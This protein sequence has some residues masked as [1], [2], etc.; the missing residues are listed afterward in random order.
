MIVPTYKEKC[1][2]QDCVDCRG[3]QLIH[4]LKIWERII[5]RMLRDKQFVFMSGRRTA[6]AIFAV[7]QR[8]EK[9]RG[10]Q[11]CIFI[12]VFI[13]YLEKTYDIVPRQEVWRRKREGVKEGPDKYTRVMIVGVQDMYEGARTQAKTN[14]MIR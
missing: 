13:I 14:D 11:D 5:E 3:I 7:R 6:D 1:D 2:M 10:K 8:M 9:H 12:L 4:N